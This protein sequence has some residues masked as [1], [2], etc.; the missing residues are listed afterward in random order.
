MKLIFFF[1]IEQESNGEHSKFILI[2]S[3]EKRE[4]TKMHV[5]Q[6]DQFP[7]HSASEIKQLAVQNWNLILFH[8]LGHQPQSCSATGADSQCAQPHQ[9]VAR[10]LWTLRYREWEI[11]VK[12]LKQ[13]ERSTSCSFNEYK[14]ALHFIK[15]CVHGG[16]AEPR[17]IAKTAQ[18]TERKSDST[19]DGKNNW[20]LSK[21]NY[22]L[23]VIFLSIQILLLSNDL[24]IKKN[25][26][27]FVTLS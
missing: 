6:R 25:E 2:C 16:S 4:V 8:F 5:Y 24:S 9:F 7:S 23:K 13:R 14:M 21:Q 11:K 20:V 17:S 26:I 18:F 10:P 12:S 22:T 19:S 27:S 1:A 15:W 3:K